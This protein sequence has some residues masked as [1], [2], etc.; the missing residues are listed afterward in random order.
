MARQ[1]PIVSPELPVLMPATSP[2]LTALGPDMVRS[3]VGS[4]GIWPDLFGLLVGQKP[5]DNGPPILVGLF[6]EEF[7]VTT[8]VVNEAVRDMGARE[9]EIAPH[10][11]FGGGW[12]VL[13]SYAG[14]FVFREIFAS[15]ALIM[16]TLLTIP[17]AGVLFQIATP[18]CSCL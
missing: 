3:A 12:D 11:Q 2:R 17:E 4:F 8:D 15:T 10:C 6:F 13:S 9:P 14:R 1:A 16:A 7:S 5:A 18:P